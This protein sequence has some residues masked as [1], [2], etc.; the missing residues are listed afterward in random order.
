MKYICFLRG[1]NVGGNTKVSMENIRK[2]FESLHATKV[3][4]LLN[5]GNIV[6]EI[7]E[8]NKA[9]LQETIEKTL[10]KISGFHIS[11]I[12]REASHIQS[13]VD[14]S[15]FAGI[16]I[17]PQRRFYVTFLSAPIQTN[18]SIPFTSKEKDFTIL[19]V[20]K[21]EVCSVVIIT[22]SKN[23]TDAMKILEK[24]FGKQV[25]TRNWNTILKIYNIL[26]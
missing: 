14:S 12:L 18:L 6:F 21:T 13:L 9:L 15:P 26:R 22:P 8:D 5:S 20:T 7:S 17:T 4:T 11:V 24:E 19:S 3:K 2:A 16:S 10:E 25:T 23:T 1:I